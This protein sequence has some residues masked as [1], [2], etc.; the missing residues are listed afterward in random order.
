MSQAAMQE[1]SSLPIGK[2]IHSAI[3]LFIMLILP[4]FGSPEFAVTPTEKLIAMGFPMAGDQIMISLTPVGMSVI[5]LFFGLIYFWTAVDVNW[6]TFLAIYLLGAHS[7]FA[8]MNQVL[9]MFLGNPNVVLFFHF[10]IF[11][12]VLIKS[13]LGVY[14]A[15]YFMTREIAQGRPWLLVTMILFTTYAVA[16]L[17]QVSSVFIMWPVVYTI[18]TDVGYKKGDKFV[19]WMIVGVVI[20]AM[21]SFATDAIKGGAFILV[22]TANQLSANP[23]LG[24]APMNIGAYLLMG[25]ILSITITALI[26][27]AMRFIYRV[28]VSKLAAFDVAIFKKNP[29]P[30]LN[31]KQKLVI[32]Y[33]VLYASWLLL[34]GLLPANN[35]VGMYLRAN[36]MG[37]TL[38][39]M[40]LLL[41]TSYK[42]EALFE[43]QTH[44]QVYPW[45]TFFL[46]ATA[47]LFGNVL[48]SPATNFNIVLSSLLTDAFQGMGIFAIAVGL[49][50][51]A[52]VLTNFTNSVVT[53]L[54]FAP[55]LAEFGMA[56]GFN[57]VPV[58]AVFFYTVL[59]A[60]CTP[61]G[62][63][64]AALLFGN[65]DWIDAKD[66]AHYAVVS[67]I[68]VVIAVIILGIPLA[69]MFF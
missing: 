10:Y 3:A 38:I 64:Y 60:A 66:A 67:S 59:I 48:T 35:P 31:W 5:C 24:L 49:V 33:L 7:G 8:P 55:V 47:M 39:L 43:Y 30:P 65:K 32:V 25:L 20:M 45:S 18:A 41:I 6:P 56:L 57:A 68:C 11:A 23:A 1:K 12:T 21:L 22:L 40:F 26:I 27:V 54:I 17:D 9:N 63:P 16:F 42:K 19:S 2:I 50:L 29:L 4:S 37:S 58:I 36:Q 52:I 44:M 28:D 61:A 34:A 51:I 14:L 62:S 13:Q 15:R 46:I 53:G 69:Q